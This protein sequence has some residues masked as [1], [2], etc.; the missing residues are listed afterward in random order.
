MKSRN[1]FQETA[2]ENEFCFPKLVQQEQA[3]L[4]YAVNVSVPC[5]KRLQIPGVPEES[6]PHMLQSFRCSHN[7]CRWQLSLDNAQTQTLQVNTEKPTLPEGMQTF[8]TAG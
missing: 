4:A 1:S 8:H 7:S 2:T 5:T 3:L 6:R